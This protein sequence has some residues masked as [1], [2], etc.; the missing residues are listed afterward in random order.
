MLNLEAPGTE[1]PGCILRQGLSL[2]EPEALPPPPPPLPL[3]LDVFLRDNPQ[4]PAL[5]R[6]V[7]VVIICHICNHVD[8]GPLGKEIISS[9]KNL[10]GVLMTREDRALM[11]VVDEF[12]WTSLGSELSST[13]H[14]VMLCIRCSFPSSVGVAGM[15]SDT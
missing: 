3:P 4:V 1:S 13:S 6:D 14:G 2:S 8:E 15:G 10:F 9:S 5:I 7:I 12:F 11:T